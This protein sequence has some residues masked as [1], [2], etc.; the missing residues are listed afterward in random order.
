[1]TVQPKVSPAADY[2]ITYKNQVVP[3]AIS[4]L[5]LSTVL[6]NICVASGE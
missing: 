5:S 2:K 6:L 1:M 4:Y 3:T